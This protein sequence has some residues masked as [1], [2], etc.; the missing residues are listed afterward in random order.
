MP[1][2][3]TY[4]LLWVKGFLVN[5]INPFTVFFWISVIGT[6]VV[7]RGLDGQASTLFLGS[8]LCTIVATDTLK[9]LLAERIR[10]RLRPIH[11]VFLRRI[12]GVSLLLFGLILLIRVLWWE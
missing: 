5:T 1:R 8:I 2:R 7:K 6:M 3:R 9:I 11:L 12:A 10:T 4:G